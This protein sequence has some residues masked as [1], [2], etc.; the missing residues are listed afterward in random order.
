MPNNDFNIAFLNLTD[1]EIDSFEVLRQ[2]DTFHY[3]VSLKPKH[4]DCPY[5]GEKVKVHGRKERLIHHPNLND[6]DGVIHFYARRYICKVCKKTFFEENPFTFE[7]FTNSYALINRV[8]KL[9]GNLDL[10]FTRIAEL[11]H[12]SVT[13]VQLYLDSYISLPK[14]SLPECLGIDELHSKMSGGDSA[15]LCILIDNEGRFPIDILNSRSKHNLNHY[16]ETYPKSERDK[17]KYVCIDMW[18]PYKD[19]ALRQFKQCKIAVDPFHVVKH[20]CDAFTKVRLNIMNQCPYGSDAYYLLKRWNFLLEVKD[21]VI[22]NEPK[23]NNHFKRKLN[24]RQ[25][26]NMIFDISD[27]IYDAYNLKCLYQLFNDNATSD[28][29]EIW[30]NKLIEKFQSTYITEFRE[31]TSILLNWRTEIINSFYALTVTENYLIL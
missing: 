1:E 2:E 3:Y 26:Q 9:L 30:L 21:L 19:V 20:L 6:F 22:D 24:Y 10:S 14:P 31:F 28:N 23:Y 16:F 25:L 12:I 27:K 15:Y 8:M 11:N 4:Y 7:N 13:T 17:V 5:C 29:C 18:Q